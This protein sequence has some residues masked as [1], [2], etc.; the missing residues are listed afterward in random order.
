MYQVVSI[1]NGKRYRNA[2]LCGISARYKDN[3][4]K[5]YYNG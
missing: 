5:D 3:I 4:I 1:I 2:D